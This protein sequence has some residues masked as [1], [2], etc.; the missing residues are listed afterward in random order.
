MND[1]TEQKLTKAEKRLLKRKKCQYRKCRKR[2]KWIVVSGETNYYYCKK[3][4][5]RV[6]SQ[7][8]NQMFTMKTGILTAYDKNIT[9]D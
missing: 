2:A 9:R 4:Y 8:F 6:I 1:P 7:T 3:H 5:E